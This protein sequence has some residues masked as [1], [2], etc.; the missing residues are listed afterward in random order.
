MFHAFQCHRSKG[1]CGR[2]WR[3]GR[4]HEQPAIQH[5]ELACASCVGRL[6]GLRQLQTCIFTDCKPQGKC[7]ALEAKTRT[8][9]HSRA[10]EGLDF[11]F[12]T[13]ARP[14]STFGSWSRLNFTT[15]QLGVGSAN[16]YHQQ[17]A[18]HLLHRR[19]SHREVCRGHILPSG[20]Q[21]QHQCHRAYRFC[22]P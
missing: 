2:D 3:L 14:L 15:S 21:P 1:V 10:G 6:G 18:N 17:R 5:R 12:S 8:S 7:K 16:L 4:A 9:Q 13:P 22:R 19:A 11:S 20:T